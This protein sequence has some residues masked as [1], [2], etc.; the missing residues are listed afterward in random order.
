MTEQLSTHKEILIDMKVHK[1][2]NDLI[3]PRFS[4]S[5]G[6]TDK[7]QINLCPIQ[8]NTIKHH[9]ISRVL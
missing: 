7:N 2:K 1:N 4:S 3:V 9:N 8:W 5:V 6:L